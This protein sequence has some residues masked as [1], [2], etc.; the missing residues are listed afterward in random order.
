MKEF[1]H[2]SEYH[3][4]PVDMAAPPAEIMQPPQEYALPEENPT[5][6]VQ[7]APKK[8]SRTRQLLAMCLTG[9]V[10][11][12]V[13]F[14]YFVPP[15]TVPG[16]SNPG[17]TEPGLG[18]PPDYTIEGFNI[19][20]MYSGVEDNYLKAGLQT[21]GEYFEN[22]DYIRASLKM[23]DAVCEFVLDYNPSDL[24]NVAYEFHNSAI[25]DFE[26][27]AVNGCYFYFDIIY[28]D[29]ENKVG[30]MERHEALDAYIVSFEQRSN[31][32]FYRVINAIYELPYLVT[33]GMTYDWLANIYYHEGVL[34]NNGNSL[35]FTRTCFEAN[36]FLAQPNVDGIYEVEAFERLTGP[37]GGYA[38]LNGSQLSSWLMYDDAERDFIMD[39]QMRD[40]IVDVH[41]LTADGK[42][43]LKH[44]AVLDASSGMKETTWDDFRSNNALDV[45]VG[46]SSVFLKSTVDRQSE[47]QISGIDIY[48][49]LFPLDITTAIKI[50]LVIEQQSGQNQPGEESKPDEEFSTNLRLE[51]LADQN[52][53]S[54]KAYLGQACEK[55]FSG[56]YVSASLQCRA[57]LQEFAAS[58]SSD[59]LYNTAMV[60]EN[61]T[62]SHFGGQD[63]RDGSGVYIF[64]YVTHEKYVGK[65]SDDVYTYPHLNMV[66]LISDKSGNDDNVRMMHLQLEQFYMMTQISGCNVT[67]L[68][69]TFRKGYYA[70]DVELIQFYASNIYD[71]NESS[72]YEGTFGMSHI[73]GDMHQDRLYGTIEFNEYGSILSADGTKYELDPYSTPIKIKLDQ[74]GKLDIDGMGLLHYK[75]ADGQSFADLSD[76]FM[77]DYDCPG[78]VYS[79]EQYGVLMLVHPEDS[80]MDYWRE[81]VETDPLF[82]TGRS[83]EFWRMLQQ[84]MH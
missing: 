60:W 47:L 53:D 17:N 6:K 56:D 25:E 18:G 48:E 27:N 84:H 73:K 7:V 59:D 5:P 76:A 22:S 11:I 39:Q 66:L 52:L 67:Y 34:D 9:F 41:W 70:N 69:T 77:N 30:E 21:A 38:F 4:L 31:G 12:Q 1:H 68:E 19:H 83:I 82:T 20:A 8:K 64:F 61:G 3:Q 10:T 46:P 26:G 43:D 54:M 58:H 24:D 71:W 62:I 63:L 78:Y 49:P 15:T 51:E 80:K 57:A 81:F 45:L 74:D 13:L 40:Q 28:V 29:Y 55:F 72:Y 23:M 79:Y 35:E 44:T 16:N 65:E 36:N 33:Y 2:S 50:K 42:L 37:V 14:S 75:Q 32:T